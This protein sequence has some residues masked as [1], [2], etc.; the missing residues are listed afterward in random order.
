LFAD[1]LREWVVLDTLD[2]Y[3]P[4]HDH[5]QRLETVAEWVKETGLIDV[6]ALQVEYGAGKA[7]T[8]RASRA[9]KT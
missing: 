1:E 7:A 4:A 5:P 9:A 6:E 8:V 3:S 2:V